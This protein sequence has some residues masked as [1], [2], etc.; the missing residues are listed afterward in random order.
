MSNATQQSLGP[1]PTVKQLET[2]KK[3]DD[4]ATIQ[5]TSHSRAGWS[6]CLFKDNFGER[7][8]MRTDTLDKFHSW[9]WVEAFGD[10]AWAWRGNKYRI[11]DKGRQVVR[12]GITRK[13]S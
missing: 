6:A 8:T 11:T 12:L 5:S 2:L 10:T 9:G 4:G 1:K 3:L 13:G 7:E